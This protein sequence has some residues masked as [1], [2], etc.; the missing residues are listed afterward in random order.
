MTA[1]KP[2][3]RSCW[4]SSNRGR[5]SCRV[6]LVSWYYRYN[7]IVSGQCVLAWQRRTGSLRKD[8]IFSIRRRTTTANKAATQIL[9]TPTSPTTDTVAPLGCDRR[10]RIHASACVPKLKNSTRY[11]GVLEVFSKG[12]RHLNR[13]RNRGRAAYGGL[14][15]SP[16]GH[17]LRD[18]GG[19]AT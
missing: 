1:R 16:S 5:P 19:N 14:C 18:C 13:S 2:K 17:V 8:R 6:A 15:D 12:C 10:L 3:K 11:S 7:I 9:K 4:R